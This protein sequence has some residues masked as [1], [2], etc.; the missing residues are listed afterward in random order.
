M[1]N[2]LDALENKVTQVVSLCCEL[3]AEN[4]LLRRQLAAADAERKTLAGRAETARKRIEQLVQRLPEG[5]T[6]V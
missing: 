5:K 6:K 1:L 4:N 3:R 2:E